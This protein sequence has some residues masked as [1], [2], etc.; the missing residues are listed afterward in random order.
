MGEWIDDRWMD[1]W[2][3]SMWSVS[4]VEYYVAMKRSEALTQATAWMGLEHT[5]LSEGSRHGGIPVYGKGFH[6]QEKS[7]T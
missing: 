2:I 1:G 7:Q 3:N 6:L 4:M 5:I